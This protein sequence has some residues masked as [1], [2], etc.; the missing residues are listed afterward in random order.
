[1]SKSELFRDVY[2]YDQVQA[3][4]EESVGS[5]VEVIAFI[6]GRMPQVSG[7]LEAKEIEQA[8]VLLLD[9][10]TVLAEKWNYPIMDEEWDVD[11]LWIRLAWICFRICY[12][13]CEQEDYVR[14]YYYI[15][16]VR[17]IDSDCFMEWINVLVSSGRP[18]ALLIIESYLNDPASV[19][20]IFT[21]VD[22]QK[23]I[24]DFLECRQAYLYV[25]KGNFTTARTLL[26]NLLSNAASSDFARKELEYLNDLEKNE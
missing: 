23:K 6:D 5:L 2:T 9:T 18:D 20:E 11:A 8:L 1:M 4:G 16:M 3:P 26:T 24:M 21:E 7:M 10:Y 15:D 19:N 12:C 22:E 25:E 13:Y 17:S 14:A